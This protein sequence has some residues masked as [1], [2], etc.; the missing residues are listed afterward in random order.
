MSSD[1]DSS[2]E[3]L[4]LSTYPHVRAYYELASL[5]QLA[6]HMDVKTVL[7]LLG[8][9]WPTRF[10]WVCRPRGEALT[11]KALATLLPAGTW[12]DHF[13]VQGVEL[14]CLVGYGRTRPTRLPDARGLAE[15]VLEANGIRTTLLNELCD[16]FRSRLDI[17]RPV[18]DLEK[19]QNFTAACQ[20]YTA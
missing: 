4:N 10:D 8:L 15:T 3:S 2:D 1:N 16:E 6:D 11:T 7:K 20:E 14:A 18:F 17:D 19:F 13:Q 12:C 5:R 9:Q